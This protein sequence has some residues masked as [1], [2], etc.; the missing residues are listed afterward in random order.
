[1]PIDWNDP[2][3][4]FLRRDLLASGYDDRAIRRRIRSGEWCRIRRGAFCTSETWRDAGPDARHR[5]TARAVMRTAHPSAVL[6]HTS[7]LVER[8]IP[9]WNVSLADVHLTR[10]DGRSGRHEAGVVHHRGRLNEWE[11]ELVNGL[12]VTSAGRAVVELTSLADVESSLVSANWALAEQ[13]CSRPEIAALTRRFAHWPDTLA[14][15]LVVRLAEPR[16]QWPGEARTEHLLRSRH[17]PSAEPQYEVY[18]EAGNL[19]A[20]VDFAWPEL[21]VFLEFDGNIKYERL[22][23]EGQTVED[24]IRREKQREELVCLLTGWVCIRITWADLARP[25]K[26]SRRIR[27]LLDGRRRPIAA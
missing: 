5:L 12:R 8:G 14:S 6:S 7:S 17:L 1:M 25:E 27:A 26:T 4:V 15:D 2:H 18:D 19:A 9:V 10:T 3:L 16:C 11:V 22:R 13:T 21:G 23:R 20:V 24:V